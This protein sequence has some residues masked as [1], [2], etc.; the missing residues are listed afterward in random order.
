M[1][2]RPEQCKECGR[3]PE[4][5]TTISYRGVCSVCS[6]EAQARNMIGLKLK[7]GPAYDKWKAGRAEA[8]LREAR[9]LESEVSGAAS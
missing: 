6:S 2:R 5:L 9:A 4:G 3:K 7:D 8:I 1:R